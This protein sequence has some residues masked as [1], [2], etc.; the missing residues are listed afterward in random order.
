MKFPIFEA[1]MLLCFGLAWPL[2][3]IKSWRSRTSKGKSLF[4]LLVVL[5]GYISGL[6]HKLWWQSEI[7]G[8]VWLYVLNATLIFVDLMIY[9]RNSRLDKVRG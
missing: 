8:V 4:F 7:D 5:L 1:I 3:I 9:A 2:S 6:T